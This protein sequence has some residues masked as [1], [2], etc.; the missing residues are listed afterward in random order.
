M[1]THTHTRIHIYTQ[2]KLTLHLLQQL[3]LGGAQGR[4]MPAQLPDMLPVH[5]IKV[6]HGVA[7]M[8]PKERAVDTDAQGTGLAKGGQGFVVLHTQI[9]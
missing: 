1:H 8:H 3:G 2:S 9:G 7:L 4:H 5:F 6:A